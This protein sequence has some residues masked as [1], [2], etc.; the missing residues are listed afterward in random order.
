MPK[1]P[2]NF[3]RAFYALGRLLFFRVRIYN[4]GQCGF[5]CPIDNVNL[6]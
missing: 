6:S 3:A 5:T 4:E 2:L 1:I